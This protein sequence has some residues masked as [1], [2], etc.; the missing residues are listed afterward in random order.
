MVLGVV[1][2]KPVKHQTTVH[3]QLNNTKVQAV[4][5]YLEDPIQLVIVNL[6][7]NSVLDYIAEMKGV[8]YFVF[9][10]EGRRVHFMLFEMHRPSDVQNSNI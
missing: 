1:I 3:T 7:V 4:S 6:K 8:G 10:L 2:Q 5:T 9:L